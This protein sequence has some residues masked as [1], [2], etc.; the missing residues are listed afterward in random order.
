M[1]TKLIPN[2]ITVVRAFG[3]P[4]NF[5][6]D[7]PIRYYDTFIDAVNLGKLDNRYRVFNHFFNNVYLPLAN[8]YGNATIKSE[9][10]AYPRSSIMNSVTGYEKTECF[11]VYFTAND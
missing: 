10:V 3:V 9:T 8:E 2:P 5:Y 1:T 11:T 6:L 7:V 4:T